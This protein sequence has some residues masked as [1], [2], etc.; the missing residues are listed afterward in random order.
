MYR[1]RNRRSNQGTKRYDGEHKPGA[2]SDGLRIAHVYYR[3]TKEANEGSAGSSVEDC[4]GDESVVGCCEWPSCKVVTGMGPRMDSDGMLGRGR[5][6]GRRKEDVPKVITP[7]IKLNG[8][9][10]FNVPY[11]S[12]RAPVPSRPTA[13][14]AFAIDISVKALESGT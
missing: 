2:F 1:P 11:I 6:R 5:R 9:N 4:R 10:M 8:I 14:A 12:A 7:A 13:L 3:G